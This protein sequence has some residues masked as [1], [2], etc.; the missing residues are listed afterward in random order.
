MQT[1]IRKLQCLLYDL[2]LMSIIT[3]FESSSTMNKNLS[4]LKVISLI[5][6]TFEENS[7]TGNSSSEELERKFPSA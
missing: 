2:T 5:K 3:I 4:F 7:K 1:F 6:M